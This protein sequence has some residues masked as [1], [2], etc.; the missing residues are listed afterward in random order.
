MK[1]NNI[2]SSVNFAAH[3]TNVDIGAS[4]ILGSLKIAIIDENGNLIAKNYRSTVFD[5]NEERNEDRFERNVARKIA[6][7][8][9]ANS[10]KIKDIDKSN[11]VKLTICYPGPKLRS[12]KNEALFFLSN[13]A[14]DANRHRKFQRPINASNIDSY[15][16]QANISVSQSRHANDMAGAGACLLS[17][18]MEKCPHILQE[19]EEILF[20]YP[21]GG[22]GT[23]MLIVDKGNI[24]IKPTEIQHTIKNWTS[25]EAIEENVK[26]KK[27]RDNFADELELD[28]EER[29]LIKENTK[30]VDNYDEL[31]SILPYISLEE[32]QEASK[33]AILKYMDSLAQVIATKV[34]DSKLNTIII[35]GPI[36]NGLR[37][38]VNNNPRFRNFTTESEPDN[39]KATL[40]RKVTKNL[41]KVGN[42]NILKDPNRLNIIFLDIPNNT[43]AAHMLQ[44]GEEV[45]NPTAW[46]N[47]YK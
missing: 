36:A 25:N 29:A 22:L 2:G 16:K 33:V 13:F 30:V 37:K 44:Q 7:F 26:A 46:Y 4:S 18:V 41:T 15:L 1:I 28:D 39:F 47:I 38:S 19:G 40:K 17:K 11:K 10:D 24:K 45:G 14:Y 8:E 9:Q 32:F 21:G 34:C 3:Y 12:D 31:H 23:G 5:E 6:E 43:E 27:L 20:M 35:T 42:E